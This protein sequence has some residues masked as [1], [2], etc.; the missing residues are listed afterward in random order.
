MGKYSTNCPERVEDIASSNYDSYGSIKTESMW[1]RGDHGEKSEFVRLVTSDVKLVNSDDDNLVVQRDEHDVIRACPLGYVRN[2]VSYVIAVGA[3]VVY[4]R[5]VALG[6]Y[7]KHTYPLLVATSVCSLLYTSNTS[8]LQLGRKLVRRIS[9]VFGC[10]SKN[11]S[12]QKLSFCKRGGD[13]NMDLVNILLVLIPI[14]VYAVTK[15]CG[16]MSE[17]DFD[18]NRIPHKHIANDFGKISAFAMSAFLVPV[19]RHSIL[20]KCLGLDPRHGLRVH[21]FSGYIA[22]V[23]GLIHGLYW[24]SIW[25]F[26]EK[27]EFWDIFPSSKCWSQNGLIEGHGNCSKQFV[28]LTGVICGLCFVGLSVTSLWWIRRNYYRFF[29]I[30]HVVFSALLLYGLLMHYRKMVLYLSPSLV[31]YFSSC[32]PA[33]LQAYVSW[34]KEGSRITDIVHIPGSR[35]CV[36][37]SLQLDQRQRLEE[38]LFGKYVRICVP[39]ISKVW[40][41]FTV[42]NNRDDPNNIKLTFRC[43]GPFTRKLSK[44]LSL[45]KSSSEILTP[46]IIVDGY[47]GVDDRLSKAIDHEKVVIV[48]GGVG[49]V[50]YISLLNSLCSATRSTGCSESPFRI[51]S[52]VIH[53]ICRD[54]GLI[55]HFLNHYLKFENEEFRNVSFQMF[56]HHTSES[57]NGNTYAEEWTD[58]QE[59]SSRGKP[60]VPYF[61]SGGHAKLMKNVVTATVFS[62]LTWGNF[63]IISYYY[64][65][66]QNKAGVLT[67]TY[68]LAAIFFYSAVISAFGFVVLHMMSWHSEDSAIQMEKRE[69]FKKDFS[70]VMST[71]TSLDDLSSLEELEKQSKACEI[72][73]LKG[74]PNF[75]RDT[76]NAPDTGVFVCGPASLLQLVRDCCISGKCAMYQ[77]EF[78]M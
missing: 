70:S 72:Q 73:H 1:T 25:A 50:S 7:E 69:N 49:I 60:L 32:I 75:E 10:E 23:T 31:Y 51:K 57:S 17:N 22:V 38:S 55:R 27:K 46:E 15:V 12:L 71:D 6:N 20:L 21:I 65:N 11:S 67:R 56:I 5:R 66:V 9:N 78:E 33:L 43:T 62:L 53:W 52:L 42:Y 61:L 40:H 35:G 54:E 13:P 44:R 2:F 74:R 18:I 30:C 45:S 41:P 39:D 28:N 14:T 26:I 8:Q 24:I 19:A 58:H 3:I 37:L 48:A 68:V 4:C 34:M 76:F 77:E 16:H 47:H 59:L 36:E 29:Y 63:R 64:N